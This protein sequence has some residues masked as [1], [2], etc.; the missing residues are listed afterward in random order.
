M[1][2]T[3]ATEAEA[4]AV[5][6]ETR[7]TEAEARA[8]HVATR[9]DPVPASAGAAS[10]PELSSQLAT[11]Q[12]KLEHTETRAKRAYAEAE[13]ARAELARA[14]KRVEAEP[15]AADDGSLQTEV[16][17]LGVELARALERTH[18]AEER[19]AR[20]E[21]ELVALHN[22]MS[23]GKGPSDPIPDGWAEVGPRRNGS[24]TNEEEVPDA[25]GNEDARPTVEDLPVESDPS[26]SAMTDDATADPD[27]QDP[28]EAEGPSLRSRLARSAAQKKGRSA[29]EASPRR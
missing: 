7:A 5:E 22:G 11:L 3:R 4:R 27:V 26:E 21:A 18:A 24:R 20:L 8:A 15:D 29:E 2:E 17:R 28:S 1:A 6:A 9:S 10:D 23:L 16:D 13:A 25:G 12:A 19:G 14:S